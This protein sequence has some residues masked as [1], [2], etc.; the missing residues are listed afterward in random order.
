[1]LS[2]FTFVFGYIFRSRWGL[3]RE[4]R[5]HFALFLFTGLIVF[6]AF[7]E[8]I[9]RAPGLV[10]HQPHYVKKILFPLE[11]L[12]VVVLLS[13]IVHA[14]ISFM[15]LLCGL[16]IGLGIRP[17]TTVLFPLTIIPLLLFCLGL[18]WFLASIGVFF[19]DIGHI[20]GIVTT[21]VLFLSPI[22]YPV[23][24]IPPWLQP[25]Y[26]LNPLTVVIEN[27]RAVLIWGQLP[28]WTHLTLCVVATLAFSLSGYAWFQHTR[29]GFA[30]V[31]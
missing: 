7:A 19:R 23:S 24:A 1:M 9:N 17:W 14:G 25:F 31:L 27:M 2:V 28:N 18:C 6:N 13:S 10:L 12:P 3:E 15:V 22:F 5:L 8:C 29:K 30:D 21:T 26:R 4:G 16:W 20:I 11:I